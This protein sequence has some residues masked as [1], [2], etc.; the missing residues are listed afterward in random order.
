MNDWQKC[1]AQKVE[2]VRKTSRERFEL[3]AD[4]AA[5]PV[6]EEFREF[7]AQQGFHATAPMAKPGIRIFKFAVSE[8]T[9]VLMT[10]R[11]AGLEHCE[12]RCEFFVPAREK[13]PALDLLVELGDAGVDWT[14]GIFESA[15]DQFMDAFLE[16]FSKRT[17]LCADLVDA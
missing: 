7:T 11:L 8:N 6:F 13:L 17:D 5:T 15:L 1:F 4:E 14:R 12:V 9:Y 2:T 10:F 3:F 16:S